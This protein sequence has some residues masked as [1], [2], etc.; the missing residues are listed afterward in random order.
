MNENKESS[1]AKTALVLTAGLMA[2]TIFGIGVF[3]MSG[4]STRY[5]AGWDGFIA[6]AVLSYIVFYAIA[7]C[8]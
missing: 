5:M 1:P 3:V 4:G 6:L 8:R 7:R 2:F